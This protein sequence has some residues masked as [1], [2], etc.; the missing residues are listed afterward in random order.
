MTSKL[1]TKAKLAKLQETI[2]PMFQD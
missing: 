1:N 2:K